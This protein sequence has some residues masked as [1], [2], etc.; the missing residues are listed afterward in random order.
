MVVQFAEFGEKAGERDVLGRRGWEDELS[1][2]PCWVEGW[3]ASQR[4]P[5]A[6]GYID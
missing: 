3:W 5:E 6:L 2:G 1:F 4:A